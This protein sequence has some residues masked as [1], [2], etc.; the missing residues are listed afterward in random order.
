MQLSEYYDCFIAEHSC[1]TL[2]FD[3]FLQTNE[4]YLKLCVSKY[5]NARKKLSTVNING[6]NYFVIGGTYLTPFSRCL[7]QDPNVVHLCVFQFPFSI[8]EILIFLAFV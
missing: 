7:A 4:G 3:H 1:E 2:D 6:N 5:N 8:N